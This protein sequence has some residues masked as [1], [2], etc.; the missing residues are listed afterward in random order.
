MTLNRGWMVPVAGVA[1]FAVIQDLNAR[2]FHWMSRKF[3]SIDSSC[4]SSASTPPPVVAG[5]D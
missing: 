3:A 4:A 5:D 1:T 2:I